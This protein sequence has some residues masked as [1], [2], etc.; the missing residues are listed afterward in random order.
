MTPQEK[1]LELLQDEL[2]RH[3]LGET[4]G[5]AR[6]AFQCAVEAMVKI[7]LWYR[8]RS[9]IAPCGDAAKL[10]IGPETAVTV[11]GDGACTLVREGRPDRGFGDITSL[12]VDRDAAQT[13][14]ERA[15]QGPYLEV[16][17]FGKWGEPLDEIVATQS[18]VS[19]RRDGDRRFIISVN[20]HNFLMSA[21][22]CCPGRQEAKLLF[23]C[24]DPQHN[25]ATEADGTVDHIP[26][27]E[28]PDPEKTDRKDELQYLDGLEGYET[29][30]HLEQMSGQNFWAGMGRGAYSFFLEDDPDEDE[31]EGDRERQT[32]DRVT[33][34][35]IHPEQD[36]P[37]TGRVKM[38]GEEQQPEPNL[39]ERMKQARSDLDWWN[40][41]QRGRRQPEPQADEP[42]EPDDPEAQDPGE[43][44]LNFLLSA[45]ASLS[46]GALILMILGGGDQHPHAQPLMYWMWTGTLPVWV[47]ALA[48]PTAKMF[49]GTGP[50]RVSPLSGATAITSGVMTIAI[51]AGAMNREDIPVTVIYTA[52]GTA[53]TTATVILGYLASMSPWHKL[54]GDRNQT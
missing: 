50:R 17:N 2:L 53:L 43:I 21:E 5:E 44:L 9:R 20:E 28:R 51:L 15:E 39:D 6:L 35:R 32:R 36:P 29:S 31:P 45:A 24:T 30:M 25:D 48:R 22:G 41:G 33:L 27:P 12:L 3:A 34:T 37:R 14:K 7:Y 8:V 40:Q 42:D 4:E 23:A 47:A 1:E 46:A 13:L 16:R 11:T 10:E 54:S 49:I 38:S 52:L 18:R 19:V 26:D